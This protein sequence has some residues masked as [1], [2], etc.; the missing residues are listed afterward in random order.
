MTQK[1]I[2]SGLL[3]FLAVAFISC[4]QNEDAP[5]ITFKNAAG[6]ILISDAWN[7][8][9]DTTELLYI[10]CGF[11]EGGYILY[12]RFVDGI[13]QELLPEYQE[14]ITILSEGF[15]NNLRTENAVIS[16][17]FD[18]NYI[19]HGSEVKITV[20]DRSEMAKTLTYIVR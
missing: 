6:D 18:S 8:N 19:T 4:A 15:K 5:Y 13:L 3:L 12:E 2:I 11:V 1:S 10:E 17:T 9:L 14:D 7:V 20:R 16:T